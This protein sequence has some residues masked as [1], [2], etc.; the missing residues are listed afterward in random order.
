MIEGIRPVWLEVNLDNLVHNIREIKKNLK[1]STCIMGVV[2]ADGYGH[3]A[4][5]V[6]RILLEEGAKQ[7]A[8]AV[9]DEGIELRKAGIEVP[10]LILGYTPFNVYE[11]LFEYDITPVIYNYQDAVCLS[12]MA[13]DKNKKIKIHIKLDTGMGRIG[14]IPGEDSL[15]DVSN[16]YKLD[17]IIVEG[18]FTHFSVA[19]IEDK[20]YTLMQYDKYM[21]FYNKLA[22]KGVAIPIKHVCNSAATIDLP[23]MHMDMVRP[24]VI[25]YGYYPDKGVRKDVVALKPVASL[26]ARVS[27]VKIIQ[28]GASIG[29]GR[30]FIAPSET[31]IATLPLGYADGYSRIL[32]GKVNVLINGKEAPVAGN[33]CMDQ[34]MVDVTEIE[35][36]KVGDEAVLIGSQGDKRISAEDLGG[37]MGTIPYEVLCMISK[38]VPRVYIRN[39]EIA[40]IKQGVGR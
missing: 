3:G 15:E 21:D 35:G 9:L 37:L 4:I 7:L 40:K 17:G 6:A 34:C 10:I 38:R 13:I 2:K 26:K 27:N 11:Q 12:K 39:G 24:G 28:P 5:E 8:V 36:V 20:S 32:S 16:I 31:V 30:K 22:A 23:D 33:I 29:Y 1:P 14:F 25:L 19:D 18:M